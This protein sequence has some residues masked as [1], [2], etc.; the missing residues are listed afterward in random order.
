VASLE[1][2]APKKAT[3]DRD[4]QVIQ[5]RVYA[6]QRGYSP[7]AD[8]LGQWRKSYHDIVTTKPVVLNTLDLPPASGTCRPPL[9]VLA[10]MTSF[11]HVVGLQQMH[12]LHQQYS[13]Q[14]SSALPAKG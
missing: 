5:S 2:D 6:L 11:N 13:P 3:R 10:Y 12:E 4:K 14:N 9:L 1:I 8:S 7:D